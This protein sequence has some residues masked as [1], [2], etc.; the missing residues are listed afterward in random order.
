VQVS[1][2][3]LLVGLLTLKLEVQFVDLM[4]LLSHSCYSWLIRVEHM[5]CSNMVMILLIVHWVK[6]V[7]GYNVVNW[8]KA[9]TWFSGAFIF[10]L[11]LGVA[12]TGYVLVAG[13]MS[14]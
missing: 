7:S 13:N 1:T 5:L 6:S 11:A 4:D 3:V 2:G 8:L 10:L 9:V 14:Y 12:F